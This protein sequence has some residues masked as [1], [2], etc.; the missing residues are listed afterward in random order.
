VIVPPVPVISA[1]IPEGNAP[2]MLLKVSE[3]RVLLLEPDRFAVTTATTPLPTAV[4][5]VPLATQVRV[6]DPG[7]QVR[8]SPADVK[9][10]P[11]EIATD[12]MAV[13]G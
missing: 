3:S 7:A 6:P 8:V 5:V 4:A 2:K 10:E 11:A 12:E 9:A 1:F 13:T